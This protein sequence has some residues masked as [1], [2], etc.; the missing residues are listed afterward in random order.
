MVWITKIGFHVVFLL[1]RF[2]EMDLDAVWTKSIW[3]WQSEQGLR[4]LRISSMK[5]YYESISLESKS[6]FTLTVWEITATP[7]FQ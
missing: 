7:F 2:P 5:A 3:G 4:L 6:L 1:S